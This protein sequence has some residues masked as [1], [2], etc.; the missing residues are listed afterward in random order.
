MSKEKIEAGYVQV[1]ASLLRGQRDALQKIVEKYKNEGLTCTI[2]SL[3]RHAVYEYLEKR[4]MNTNE[5]KTEV[6]K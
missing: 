6:T 1:S 2:T 5:Q 3:I 4:L